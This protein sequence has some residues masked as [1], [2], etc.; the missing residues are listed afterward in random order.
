VVGR[1]ISH[2]KIVEKLGEGGMGIVYRAEDIRLQRPVALKFLPANSLGSAD[3][4]ARFLREARAAAALQHSNICT[5]YEIDEAE[6]QT[7]I[8]MAYLEGHELGQEIEK[9]PLEIDRLVE[10]ATQIANGLEAAHSQ[11]VVHRDVKPANV[12]V[13]S[14]GQAIVMDFGLAQVA[15]EASKLTREG[16]TMGTS[17][18]MS[19]EQTTGAP[20]DH[21]TDIWSLGVVLY[22]MAT[23]NLPFQGHYEQAVLYSIINDPPEPMNTLRSGIPS[24]FER[25]VEK[26]LAKKVDERYQTAGGLIADLQALSRRNESATSSASREEIPSI[27]VLPF[28]NRSR[29]DEDEYFSDGISED[30]TSALGKV[31]GLHVTPRSMAFQFKGKRP[32]PEEV[33]RTLK[34]KHVLEGTVRRAGDRVRINVELI[35]IDGQYQLWSERYDRVMDDIFEIQDDISQAIV[36]QLRVKLVGSKKQ[37]LGKRYTENVKAYNLCLQGRY[38][39]WKRTP[40]TIHKAMICYERALVE[41]PNYALAHAWLA[42]CYFSKGYYGLLP[43]K[44][45]M[46]KSEAAAVKAIQIDAE[47]ADA[48]TALGAVNAIYHWNWAEAERNLQRSIELDPGYPVAHVWYSAFILLGQ[49]RLAEAYSEWKRATELDPVT[50]L[51]NLGPGTV[52]VYQR[53]PDQALEELKKALDLDPNFFWT[54]FFIGLAYLQKGDY[55]RAIS[56]LE[57]GDVSQ[58]RDGHLGYAYAVSG[59]PEAAR[60]LIEE[61]RAG[62]RPGYLVPYHLAIIYVGLGEKDKAFACLNEACDLRSSQLY[63][64]KVDPQLSSISDDPRFQDILRRMNLA[65]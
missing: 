18:Y 60:K 41:D 56:A 21:R 13:T 52:R 40:E 35:A 4:K 5:I 31:D 37:G 6:G 19:P 44:E 10:L 12:M 23:G 61:L 29:G 27:A 47:L 8:A 32:L 24:G 62:S 22:E 28:E 65:D 59:R 30:I 33:G 48:Y 42:D 55:D 20:L 58:H 3:A 36:E 34:V 57:R 50:P 11:G 2:Y 25:I 39:W 54:H 17:S 53:K 14:S 43:P 7:F 9:G 38:Q 15:A 1:T 49:G 64:L 45:A 46:P 16:A 63:W 51:V 26:C